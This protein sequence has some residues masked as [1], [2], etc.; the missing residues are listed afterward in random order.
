MHGVLRLLKTKCA[1]ALQNKAKAQ[2]RCDAELVPL[3]DSI[4]LVLPNWQ[5]PSALMAITDRFDV[6][7]VLILSFFHPLQLEKECVQISTD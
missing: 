5:K 2:L 7:V 3:A 4:D 6:P 1:R